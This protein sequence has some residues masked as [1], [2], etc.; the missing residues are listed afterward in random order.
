MTILL[1]E[2]LRSN[3]QKQLKIWSDFWKVKYIIYVIGCLKE[4]KL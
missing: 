1:P 2:G 4:I 3:G